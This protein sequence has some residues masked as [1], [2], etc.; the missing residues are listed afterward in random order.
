MVMF[1]V[2]FYFKQVMENIPLNLIPSL[3]IS[4]A[5]VSINTM[6]N[7][8]MPNS[9]FKRFGLIERN[10]KK[11]D[12]YVIN[13]NGKEMIFYD[14]ITHVFGRG[15]LT[16][17]SFE[18]D[19]PSFEK[20]YFLMEFIGDQFNTLNKVALDRKID[21]SKLKIR[22]QPVSSDM[23]GQQIA[24]YIPSTHEIFVT[25]Y[26]NY[27]S[28]FEYP[29][30]HSFNLYKLFILEQVVH[31]VYGYNF[32][33]ELGLSDND[34]T[35]GKDCIL[36]TPLKE[37]TFANEFVNYLLWKHKPNAFENKHEIL[38]FLHCVLFGVSSNLFTYKDVRESVIKALLQNRETMTVLVNQLIN[39]EKKK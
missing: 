10:E 16:S 11:Y 8:L 23:I 30:L 24:T 7:Q 31:F 17:N 1:Q 18:K 39:L 3:T 12:K 38:A 9:T 26:K 19:F 20:S 29:I 14:D 25:P 35:P 37:R 21:L 27:D 34:P 4:Q 28:L 33:E 15:Q 5:K 22:F 2:N 32:N 6:I 13:N 36:F